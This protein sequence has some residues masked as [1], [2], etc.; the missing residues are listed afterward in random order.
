[1]DEERDADCLGGV[2]DLSAVGVAQA[3]VQQVVCSRV[4]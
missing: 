2:V 4:T 1:M 3:V